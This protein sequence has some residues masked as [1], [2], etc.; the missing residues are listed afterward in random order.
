M[1]VQEEAAA[2]GVYFRAE[3]EVVRPK[4]IFFFFWPGSLVLP[5][6]KRKRGGSIW[7]QGVM[8]V[9]DGGLWWSWGKERKQEWSVLVA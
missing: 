1:V 5:L 6:P 9:S 8:A 3:F 7:V 2:K 4:A